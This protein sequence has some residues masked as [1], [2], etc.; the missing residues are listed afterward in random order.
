[1]HIGPTF[2][3]EREVVRAR[4]FTSSI[5]PPTMSFEEW[6]DIVTAK[7]VAKE[8]REAKQAE[9]R[10]RSLRELAETGACRRRS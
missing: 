1:M 7:R 3:V 4:V 8:A 6:G 10:V 9:G 2:D 5:K